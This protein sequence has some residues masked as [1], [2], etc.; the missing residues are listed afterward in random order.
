MEVITE[1]LQVAGEMRHVDTSK[2]IMVVVVEVEVM[3]VTYD[4]Q[5]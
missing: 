2:W 3:V 5:G 1:N 4:W